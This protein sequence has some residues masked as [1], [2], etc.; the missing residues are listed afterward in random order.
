MWRGHS[1]AVSSST[2]ADKVTTMIR[3][4]CGTISICPLK[5]PGR[6]EPKGRTTAIAAELTLLTA[7]EA[8]RGTTRSQPAEKELR[9]PS[10]PS[11]T[12][13]LQGRLPRTPVLSRRHGCRLFLH[14]PHLSRAVRTVRSRNRFLSHVNTSMCGWAYVY[15]SV[16]VRLQLFSG[17][18]LQEEVHVTARQVFDCS[19]DFVIRASIG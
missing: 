2:D 17:C 5:E 18:G 16:L 11:C 6:S 15:V 12:P 7:A 4:N 10:S 19:T 9:R 13:S 1:T 8:R 14:H 3:P